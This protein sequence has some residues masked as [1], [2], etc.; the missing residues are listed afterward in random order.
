MKYY[1]LVITL[2]YISNSHAGGESVVEESSTMFG[3]SVSLMDLTGYID[4]LRAFLP[5]AEKSSL[6]AGSAGVVGNGAGP[7]TYVDQA[8]VKAWDKMSTKVS[9]NSLCVCVRVFF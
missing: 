8:L 9:R 6:S 3:P 1:P 2:L 7:M 5:K 4:Q